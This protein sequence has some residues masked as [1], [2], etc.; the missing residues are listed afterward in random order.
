MNFESDTNCNLH[1]YS[2]DFNDA[3]AYLI[4]V[5]AWISAVNLGLMNNIEISFQFTLTVFFDCAD[6][7]LSF[8]V[9]PSS[10]DSSDV[11]TYHL[12]QD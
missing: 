5:D 3:G 12:G 2:D 8:I 7:A 6:P 1:V 9:S 11:L 10:I 4:K